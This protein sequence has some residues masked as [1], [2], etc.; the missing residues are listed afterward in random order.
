MKGRNFLSDTGTT[1][2]VVPELDDVQG[3]AL[4]TL[5]DGSITTMEEEKLE[6][7]EALKG[8]IPLVGLDAFPLCENVQWMKEANNE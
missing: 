1:K 8:K 7:L 2:I 3:T 6:G 4:V 5:T